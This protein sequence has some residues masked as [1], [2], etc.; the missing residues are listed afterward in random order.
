[1]QTYNW[2][3]P[4]FQSRCWVEVGVMSY[5]SCLLWKLTA[6]DNDIEEREH[7]KR[8]AKSSPWPCSWNDQLVFLTFSCLLSWMLSCSLSFSQSHVAPVGLLSCSLSV[9]ATTIS[10]SWDGCFLSERR[11]SLLSA[12]GLGLNPGRI[13]ARRKNLR[14]ASNPEILEKSLVDSQAHQKPCLNWKSHCSFPSPQSHP[15]P[16]QSMQL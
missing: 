2:G 3:C 16:L 12:L 13:I 11:G 1:M 15:L 7:D 9:S 5:P 14:T 10:C 8:S 4:T 6:L